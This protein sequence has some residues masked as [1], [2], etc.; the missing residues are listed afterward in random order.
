MWY[1]LI[2]I[3]GQSLSEKVIFKD[4]SKKTSYVT[5]AV[6]QFEL[7]LPATKFSVIHTSRRVSL[8]NLY[9][10]I[11]IHWIYNRKIMFNGHRLCLLDQETYCQSL[12]SFTWFVNVCF[13]YFFDVTFL[14]YSFSIGWLKHNIKNEH[15]HILSCDRLC[16][17]RVPSDVITCLPNVKKLF[18]RW[19]LLVHVQHLLRPTSK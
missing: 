9:I 1:W 17:I 3:H 15:R 5:V 12:F 14:S 6:F 19:C 7:R 10:M 18:S 4:Y 2:A 8:A 13:I 11:A 16:A